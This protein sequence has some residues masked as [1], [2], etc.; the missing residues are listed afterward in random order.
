MKKT[1]QNIV[2]SGFQ[3][4]VLS[5]P[6][7]KSQQIHKIT[8]Q[9]ILLAGNLKYQITEF[10]G[11]KVFQKNLSYDDMCLYVKNIASQFI[12]VNALFESKDWQAKS[13][14]TDSYQVIETL[15]KAPRSISL[16]HDRKKQYILENE[17]I[18]PPLIQLG[19]MDDN[20][21]V[22][23]NRMDK[24]IQINNFLKI[25]ET[26][27]EKIDTQHKLRIYDLCC[28]KSYLTF[29]LYYYF[30]EIKHLEFEMLGVDLKPEVIER[31]NGIKHELG[32]HDI[33]FIQEDIN[34]LTYDKQVDIVVSLHACD[35]AT[36]A[37]L[38]AA[39]KSHAQ[40]ILAVPCCHQEIAKQLVSNELKWMLKFGLMKERFA[41]LVT[42]SLRANFLEN[43][44][45]QT[46]ILEFV[47]YEN[48]PKNVMIRAIYSGKFAKHNLQKIAET[49][50]ISPSIL[51]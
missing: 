29:I 36:D 11:V 40:V 43:Q 6:K 13:T 21:K 28:G 26:C 10:I 16:N 46:E 32:Y 33:C 8:V 44:G 17:Q 15:C 1:L 49:F 12:F 2:E 30:K 9:R 20:G 27:L 7:Q 25:L 3:K 50:H 37:V 35:I 38:Q 5:K 24:F 48:T 31:C 18:I 22:F 39:V 51:K 41:A 34:K 14:G 19:I 23:K 47:N 45:Y 4:L 42:D